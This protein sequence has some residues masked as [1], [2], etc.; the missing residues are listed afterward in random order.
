M[1]HEIAKMLQRYNI[2]GRDSYDLPSSPL[3][4]PDGANYRN[5]ISGIE[6]LK[7]MEALIKEMEKRK[8]PIHRVIAMGKGTNLLTF[9]ELQELA[10]MGK[11]S[12]IEI[13]VIPGPRANFDIGKHAT[14]EWGQ[15]SGV[16][17]RGS[18]NINYFLQDILRCIDAGIRGFLFYGEDL[19]FLLHRMRKNGEIPSNLVFKLSYTAGVA[20]AAGGLLAE[21]IGADSINPVTDL[22]LPMLASLR[23]AIKI[24]LDIVTVTFE[25]LGNFNRFWEGSEI[26]RVT[27]PCYIKQELDSGVENAKTKVQYCEIMRELINKQNPDLVLSEQGP[28]DLRIPLT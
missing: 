27:S 28:E 26:I 6:S 17:V 9:K 3:R 14:T 11:E 21:Q 15:F 10:C 1:M 13:I 23:K 12:K 7:E 19:L 20:N 25:I 16:R 18:D 8:V 5:E 24:P 4:F 2:P 22:T